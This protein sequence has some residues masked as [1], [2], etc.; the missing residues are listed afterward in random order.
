[1]RTVLAIGRD[2]QP[3]GVL[4]LTES[5]ARG[6]AI[7]ERLSRSGMTVVTTP[8]LQD[9][10]RLL[11]GRAFALLVIDLVNGAS[12]A[13]L[14]TVH[15]NHPHLPVAALF[16][17]GNTL[18]AAEALHAGA[19]DVLPWP[20]EEREAAALFANAKDRVP[21]VLSPPTPDGSTGQALFT[22]SPAMQLVADLVTSASEARA[23]VCISGEPGSGRTLVGETIHRLSES[24]HARPLVLVDCADGTPQELEQRLFGTTTTSVRVL[25]N[26][27]G[28]DQLSASSALHRAR[29]GSLLLR[30]LTEIPARVQGRLARALRDREALL[31][32]KGT[33]VELDV[34]PIAT[35]DT[36]ADVALREGRLRADLHRQIS[37]VTI[38]MPSLRRRREDVPLLA[39]LMLKERCRVHGVPLKTFSRSALMVTAALPWNGNAPELR[40]MLD[41]FVQSVPGGVIHLDDVLAHAS[42]TGMSEPAIDT[43]LREAKA[44]FERDFISAV[45]MRHHGRVPEAAKAMGIQRTNLYRRIRQLN[46]ARSLLSARR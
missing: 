15:A 37:Q 24:A 18:L 10:L 14:K 3:S 22:Q 33:L 40:A 42:L 41:N 13:S 20:F 4:L 38:E 17:A 39:V 31:T 46:V 29:G 8:K 23:S 5:S 44:R 25:A 43:T 2:R 9:A 19:A 7:A 21:A 36:S 28:P 30:H 35:I 6:D 11:A 1:M 27:T 16:D 34:Q 32:G 12:I 26:A 45:L